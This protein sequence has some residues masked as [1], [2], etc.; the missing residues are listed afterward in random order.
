MSSTTVVAG[1]NVLSVMVGVSS[2]MNFQ[3]LGE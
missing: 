3:P 2:W 1:S